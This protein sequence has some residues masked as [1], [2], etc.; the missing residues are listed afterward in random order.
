MAA[1]WND[2]GTV[3]VL[4]QA[5][6]DPDELP[7]P[8][9][10]GEDVRHALH[11]VCCPSTTTGGYSTVDAHSH[12]EAVAELLLSSGAD[13]F[14]TYPDGRCLLHSIIEAQ[15]QLDSFLP[16]LSQTDINRKEGQHNRSL[17]TAACIPTVRVKPPTYGRKP[18]CLSIVPGSVLGLLEKGADAL[19]V[20]DK[21]RTPLHWLCT[22]PGKYDEEQRQAFITLVEHG[23]AAV[24][25]ADKQGRKPLHLALA[26]YSD[27][28]QESLFAIKHLISTGANVN[29]SDPVTGNSTLHQVAPRLVGHA[30]RAAEATKLFRELSATLDIN[31]RN[32]LKETPVMA[33]AAAGWEGTRDPTRE[34]S[35]PKYAIANDVNH[36]TA[37]SIFV[38]LGA[39]LM[40]VDAGGKTL[41][42]ITA[43]REFPTD[44][45][46]WDQRDDVK[47]A[48]EKLMELGL[49]PRREDA[50]L[51]TAIDVAA[52]R[53]VRVT[54]QLFREKVEKKVEESDS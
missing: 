32:D 35:H 31:A 4:L 23:Q 39:D 3:K 34:I 28:R 49:D 21:G 20:D 45:S 51:R 6:L 43:S 46:D 1:R 50:E 17:L 22:L 24:N 30:E 52:A 15:G 47:S 44:G 14:A 10:E 19:A 27:R 25:M 18:P 41:L 8:R 26:V 42:H 16:R 38:D 40:A 2:L 36:A 37:L 29:E 48:F 9:T 7:A 11:E 12:K 13:P 33:L 5:G 54:M 53:N